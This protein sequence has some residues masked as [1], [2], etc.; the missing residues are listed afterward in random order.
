MPARLNALCDSPAGGQRQGDSVHAIKADGSVQRSDRGRWIQRFLF[1]HNTAR[2]RH[3]GKCHLLPGRWNRLAE[4]FAGS[5]V[6]M[7][8]AGTA[9]KRRKLAG[10]ES[11]HALCEALLQA[12][13]LFG[14]SSGGGFGMPLPSRAAP[15]TRFQLKPDWFSPQDCRRS[16]FSRR[17]RRLSQIRCQ[18]RWQCGSN[19]RL[20]GSSSFQRCVGILRDA[21]SS[22]QF[23]MQKVPRLRRRTQFRRAGLLSSPPAP[24]LMA[25]RIRRPS[26]SGRTLIRK[27]HDVAVRFVSGEIQ[28]SRTL[29]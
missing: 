4:I 1:A 2:A 12:K 6:G 20:P 16:S 26:R 28:P 15:H 8:P 25:V 13:G 23:G 22:R 11:A 9:H 7:R 5:E 17:S 14:R 10:G 29:N 18:P 3:R 24:W 27:P 21:N 19:S